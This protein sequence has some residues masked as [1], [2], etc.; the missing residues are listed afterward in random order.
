MQNSHLGDP[1]DFRFSFNITWYDHLAALLRQYVLSF[2]TKDQTF[3]MV[4]FIFFYLQIIF[5]KD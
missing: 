4:N 1:E 3:E 5:L 2:Y